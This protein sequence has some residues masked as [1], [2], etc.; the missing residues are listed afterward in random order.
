MQKIFLDTTRLL[1]AH[2]DNV[3]DEL[4]NYI[5]QGKLVPAAILLLAAQRQFRNL[6]GFDMIKDRIGDYMVALGREGCGVESGK[7]KAKKHLKEMNV[8]LI[9][10][11]LLVKIILKAGEALDGYIQT[12]SEVPYFH[13]IIVLFSHHSNMLWFSS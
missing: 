4:S 12:H 6:N 7:N 10:A 5:K 11:L 13:L 3:V 8:H 9:N 1:A 2:T